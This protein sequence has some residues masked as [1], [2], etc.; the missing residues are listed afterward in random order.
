MHSGDPSPWLAW[1]VILHKPV[2]TLMTPSATGQARNVVQRVA[3]TVP[4]VGGHDVGCLAIWVA[5]FHVSNKGG[6][7]TV[8]DADVLRILRRCRPAVRMAL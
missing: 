3:G 2:T 1:S 6:D 4:V 8:N 7:A 5:G